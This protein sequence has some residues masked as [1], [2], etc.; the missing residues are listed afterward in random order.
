MRGGKWRIGFSGAA[1]TLPLPPPTIVNG[2]GGG[3]R[4]DA[5]AE[6]HNLDGAAVIW[7]P[8]LLRFH[9]F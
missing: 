4:T 7:V 3:D 5:P 9:P 8:A 6:L 2:K 1:E